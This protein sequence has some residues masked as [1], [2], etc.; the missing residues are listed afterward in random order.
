MSCL[1]CEP[2][3]RDRDAQI[4][5][6]YKE[7]KQ[8]AVANKKLVFLYEPTPGKIL[9]MEK[10]AYGADKERPIKWVTHVPERVDG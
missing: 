10:E 2:D 8:Y 6:V 9:F 1:G 4:K 5:K 7:A 3:A